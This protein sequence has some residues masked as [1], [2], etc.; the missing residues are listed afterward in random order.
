MRDR[1]PTSVLRSEM[2]VS[3]AYGARQRIA[4]YVNSVVTVNTFSLAHPDGLGSRLSWIAPLVGG[5]VS[6][7]RDKF[8]FTPK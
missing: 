6:L 4:E 2:G 3:V 5:G 7:V 8:A 1:G